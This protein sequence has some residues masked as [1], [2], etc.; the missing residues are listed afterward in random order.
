MDFHRTFGVDEANRLVPFLQ[1]T[2]DT[3][4]PWVERVQALTQ[5]LEE[6]EDAGGP[7]TRAGRLKLLALREELALLLVRIRE[8]LERLEELGLEVKAADGLVDFYSVKAGR[9]VLLCWRY[10]EPAVSHWHELHTGFAGRK[11][12]EGSEDFNPSFLS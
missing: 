3:V 8:A 7:G 5:T 9:P 4:R 11:P 1:K 12:I 6:A 2:F 10:G